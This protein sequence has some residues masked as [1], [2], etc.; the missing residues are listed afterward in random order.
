MGGDINQWNE[1]IISGS[2]RGVLGASW[3]NDS[4]I[5]MAS[6]FRNN[7]SPTDENEFIGFRVASSIAVPEPGS[8]MLLLACAVG[9][10]I[11]SRNGN[12]SYR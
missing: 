2:T 10:G 7:D 4:S 3:V 5:Y 1:A 11:W 9:L 6:Y 8:L 12:A